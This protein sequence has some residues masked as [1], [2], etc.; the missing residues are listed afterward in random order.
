MS[1]SADEPNIS[2]AVLVV[3]GGD[4]DGRRRAKNAFSLLNEQKVLYKPTDDA[5]LLYL[6]RQLVHR[7]IVLESVTES[8]SDEEEEKG[9]FVDKT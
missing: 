5:D 8:L 9:T 4:V 3:A 6:Y 7:T 2:D 1:L